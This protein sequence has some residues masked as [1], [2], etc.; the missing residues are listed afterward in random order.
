MVVITIAA[1]P[2]RLITMHS[3]N[4]VVT[5]SVCANMIHGTDRFSTYIELCNH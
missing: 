2:L 5:I 4:H 1:L 3:F